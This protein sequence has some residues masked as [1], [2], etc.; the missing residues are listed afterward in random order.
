MPAWRTVTV[1]ETR[2]VV[3]LRFVVGS[4]R[5]S[6]GPA[7][8][9]ERS[10]VLLSLEPRALKVSLLHLVLCGGGGEQGK[11]RGEGGIGRRR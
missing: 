2:F 6:W 11:R 3:G 1:A 7:E 10:L 8:S 9:V 4:P 5:T